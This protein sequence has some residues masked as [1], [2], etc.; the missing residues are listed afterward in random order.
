MVG[1]PTD[2]RVTELAGVRHV[3]NQVVRHKRARDVR[4]ISAVR[5]RGFTRLPRLWLDVSLLSGVIS[6]MV[7]GSLRLA[8]AEASTTKPTQLRL[9]LS[10][11][12]LTPASSR[13]VAPG[14]NR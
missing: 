10:E 11:H 5:R 14:L 12:A 7:L 13:A 2:G 9:L 4:R 3:G 8:Y 1:G 6:N